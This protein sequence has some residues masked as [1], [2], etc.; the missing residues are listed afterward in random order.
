MTPITKKPELQSE[1]GQE[2]FHYREF[3]DRRRGPGAVPDS[4]LGASLMGRYEKAVGR[5]DLCDAYDFT[6]RRIPYD[7]TV[8]VHSAL[9]RRKS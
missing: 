4:L 7:G 1:G 6:L 5:K 8:I 2:L 9:L 3:I